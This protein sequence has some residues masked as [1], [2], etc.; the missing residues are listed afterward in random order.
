MSHLESLQSHSDLP[1]MMFLTV[2]ALLAL[3]APA[4]SDSPRDPFSWLNR[5]NI[6]H[7]ARAQKSL[8]GPS[9]FQANYEKTGFHRPERIKPFKFNFQRGEKMFHQALPDQRPGQ[10]VVRAS[11]GCD[12]PTGFRRG[13]DT[14]QLPG[15]RRA[16]CAVTLSGGWQTEEDTCDGL[17][18]NPQY[19]CVMEEDL[20]FPFPDCCARSVQCRSVGPRPQQ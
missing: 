10:S 20:R 13:G 15:C 6:P 3:L 1:L 19:Q 14:W 7:S 5:F 2:S 9:A 18:Q 17:I 16:T 11:G 4:L 8:R 12:T